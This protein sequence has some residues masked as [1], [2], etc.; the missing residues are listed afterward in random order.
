MP[1]AKFKTQIGDEMGSVKLRHGQEIEYGKHDVDKNQ[2][3][4]EHVYNYI[5]H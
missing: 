2:L 5:K 3:H 4:N 1:K